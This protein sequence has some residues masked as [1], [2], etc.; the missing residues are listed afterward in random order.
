MLRRLRE[1]TALAQALANQ[2]DRAVWSAAMGLCLNLAYA[3]YHGALGISLGSMWFL[4]LGAYY[5]LLSVMRFSA[6]LC[7]R[8][9]KRDPALLER[10]LTAFLG[11]M[12]I[13]LSGILAFS[14]YLSFRY[15]VAVRHQ[16][17]VMITIATYTFYKITMAVVNTVKAHRQKSLLLVA[18][19]NIGCADGLASLLTLQRSM[20]AS[21]GGMNSR[22]TGLMNAL[23]GAGVCMLTAA[24]G[25]RM[26]I[27]KEN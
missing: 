2:R 4:L 21:F 8:R 27:K 20:L 13:L 22:E 19:R 24:L 14:V 18:I 1:N 12:L 9:K 10:F 23:T 3:L 6:V 5:V 15:D 16:E 11:A 26:M 17:I 7:A 25:A